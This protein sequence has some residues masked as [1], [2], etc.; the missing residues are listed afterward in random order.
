MK[1]SLRKK[2]YA[3]TKARMVIRV[4]LLV[5]L[6]V[7]V[8][9]CKK[10]A[11]QQP[12]PPTE[13]KLTVQ[14]T[15]PDGSVQ[16]RSAG[17][18]F[19]LKIDV[20]SPMPSKGVSI[21]VSAVDSATGNS[22]YTYK[23]HVSQAL[24]NLNI[25]G[26]PTGVTCIVQVAVTSLSDNANKWTGN[27]TYSSDT[28]QI[29]YTDVNPDQTFSDS[30]LV[31]HL[32]LNNDG[33]TDFEINYTTNSETVTGTHCSGATATARYILI[34]PLNKN[35]IAGDPLYNYVSVI[36]LNNLIDSRAFTW[37]NFTNEVLASRDNY[38]CTHVCPMPPFGGCFWAVIAMRR[39]G[40]WAGAVNKY[41]ALRLYE[42][43]NIYYGWLR[44]DVASDCS[45]FIVKDYAYNLSNQSILAGQH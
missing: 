45:S 28:D 4:V 18:D 10:D 43:A 27:Y 13:A 37:K 36:K 20:T 31:Y 1:T 11:T 44:L 6:I 7:G 9:T 29:V 39:G 38:E 3:I 42:G 30:G 32:D 5:W 40:Y 34:S 15:P 17:P 26:T 23:Q 25:T 22:F 24:T 2:L 33:V 21:S 12:P 19:P 41:V 8:A 14:L 35:E 16:P